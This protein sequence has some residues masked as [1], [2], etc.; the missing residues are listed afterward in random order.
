MREVYTRRLLE[1]VPMFRATVRSAEC[2]LFAAV[3][4]AGPV[5]DVGIGDGTFVGALR[6][7]G[8]W[9]GIEPQ[10][11]PLRE[12]HG[13]GAYHNVVQAVGSPL[14]FRD[15]AF[16]AVVSNS[17]LEH[18]TDVESVLAEMVRV[19]RPGGAFV[20]S[21]P[22]EL[23]Y[24]Y[25]LGTMLFNSLRLAPLAALYRRFVR[26]TARV[27]HAD[28]PVVWR[29]RFERLGL[30][31]ESSRYY[32]SRRNTAL[33]DLWHYLS[34]PS[35][36]THAMI[37]RWVLW[38][39]KARLLPIARLIDGWTDPGRPDHGSFLFFLCRKPA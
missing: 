32:F 21:F 39:G 22:S 28:T 27:K 2:Q 5:L 18:I 29:A 34:V 6:P 9:I 13:L 26:Y 7:S 12:A 25:Y 31:V 20:V 33:M 3:D 17:T 14:P 38:P 11:K 37:G 30:E 23:F 10:R 35:L 16:G 24:D 19:L 4:L 15:S 8:C 36:A 1:M